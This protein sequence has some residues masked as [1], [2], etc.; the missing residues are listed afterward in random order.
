MS[1]LKPKPGLPQAAHLK[2]AYSAGGFLF[3]LFRILRRLSGIR[4]GL[5]ALPSFL[6]RSSTG[7]IQVRK[8]NQAAETF[9]PSTKLPNNEGRGTFKRQK[10]F[11]LRGKGIQ[12]Y[13]S[14]K[15]HA[16]ISFQS[17]SQ[18]TYSIVVFLF[19]KLFSKLS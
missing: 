16:T 4:Y 17:L 18:L 1:L 8:I 19:F 9:G 2:Q 11:S 14:K 10:R 7:N 12:L 3:F 15:K 5:S 13:Q 6:S